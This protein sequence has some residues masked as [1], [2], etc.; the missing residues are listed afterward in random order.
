MARCL[1]LALLALL[2]LSGSLLAGP[3]KLD[4]VLRALVHAQTI[5]GPAHL[6]SQHVLPRLVSLGASGMLN[7]DIVRVFLLTNDDGGARSVRA[8]RSH[9]V[10][11]R[12]ATGA[13]ALSDLS[14]LANDPQVVYVQA[15]RPVYSSLDRSVPDT[16]APTLWFSSPKA[17]GQ[18][19]IVGIVD[20]GIDILHRDFRVDRAGDGVEE[21]S[22]ILWLWDQSATEATGFPHWWGGRQGE[23][24]Y[25]RAF[26]QHELESAIASSHAPTQDTQGHGT[27]VAGIAAGDGTSMA[28]GYRG[29]APQAELVIV[30][31]TFYEDAVVDAV[32][33]VFEAADASGKPAVVNLS[34]G[35]H[36]GPHDGNS[37][38]ERMLDAMLD[39]PGRI[40]VVA[41]GN[42]GNRRIHV[43]AEVRQ[44]TTWHF[45]AE[46]SIASIQFWHGT[47]EGFLVLVRAPSGESITASPGSQRWASTSSGELWLD[48]TSNLDPL[49]S[50][51]RIYLALT[52]I[53]P[54]S[55]WTVTL[56]PVLGG[57]RV[58][59]W[60]ENPASGQFREGDTSCTISE[61]GN[62]HRV[63]TVG[64]YVTKTSWTSASGEQTADGE[65][66]ALCVFSSRGPT[67]DGRLKPDLVAPGAWIASARSAHALP[68][69]WLNLPGGGYTMLLGTS[70]AAPH[71][72][73]AVAL[74][75]SLRP[76]LTWSDVKTALISGAHVD[77]HVGTTPNNAWG[78]GKLNVLRAADRIAPPAP[79]QRP[80]LLPTANP[81][82]REAVFT[83]VCPADTRWASLNIYDLMGRLLFSASVALPSGEVRW[84]LSTLDHRSVA[85][86]LYLAVIVTDRAR[87]DLVRVVVQ[88]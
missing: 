59:G 14:E 66:G 23:M 46:R 58:D 34:L 71:V 83:Y 85:S 50:G 42:E 21:G 45:D 27:H 74:L 79:S 22:R 6:L 20:T 84:P 10:L 32:R 64:A 29:V 8:L 61:P 36:A 82:A 44:P 18:G 19:V 40:A 33:F 87:S 1:C 56:T 77:S 67:R 54:G 31:T 41:A 48:N 4:P 88:R 80:T 15:S 2:L 78:A 86:G 13:V 37:L 69:A 51:R 60:I 63:I 16:G 3:E 9:Q 49:T 47:G 25:G 7:Q 30:K 53:T 57:G 39:R 62:A 65:V 28:G 5:D 68:V 52:D 81:V 12:F 11:G 76:D 26:S 43:G 72:T 55:T 24:Y 73:G 35:G 75:L 70:M 17:T 38:F